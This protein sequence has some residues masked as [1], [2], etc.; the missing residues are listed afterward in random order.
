MLPARMQDK[1][2]VCHFEVHLVVL[3]LVGVDGVCS[4]LMTP[5]PLVGYI[6]IEI[7]CHRV[8]EFGYVELFTSLEKQSPNQYVFILVR[9]GLRCILGNNSHGGFVRH[10]VKLASGIRVRS[11][12]LKFATDDHIGLC[13]TW[14]GLV[15]EKRR[16]VCMIE[17]R[18]GNERIIVHFRNVFPAHIPR[19]CG[20]LE[21]LDGFDSISDVQGF[22][23]VREHDDV[24]VC[25]V[26]M[27]DEPHPGFTGVGDHK[28]EY[29]PRVYVCFMHSGADDVPTSLGRSG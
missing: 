26:F 10:G 11:V 4:D 21:K 27:L 13:V 1:H 23:E 15:R 28:S 6:R 22:F 19:S 14:L 16:D 18:D 20:V 24:A 12:T 7:E 3:H 5:R 17:R 29:D 2:L 9:Q 25:V 8:R